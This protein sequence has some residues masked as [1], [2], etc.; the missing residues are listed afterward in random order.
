MDK[1]SKYEEHIVLAQL[2]K[3]HDIYI[4]KDGEKTIQ[5]LY[6]NMAKGDIGIKTR[7]KIDFLVNY[8]GYRTQ[9]VK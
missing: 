8:K 5:L 2:A 1:K 7:G 4:P 9:W 3:K 6:G